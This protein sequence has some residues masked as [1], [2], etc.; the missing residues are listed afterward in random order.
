[1]NNFWVSMAHALKTLVCKISTPSHV[2]ATFHTLNS[3]QPQRHDTTIPSFR[4]CLHTCWCWPHVL[5]YKAM[6]YHKLRLYLWCNLASSQTGFSRKLNLEQTCYL[7]SC[8]W[9]TGS[10]VSYVP[11]SCVPESCIH[12]G[13]AEGFIV[14]SLV[15]QTSDYHGLDP[16]SY[17][18]LCLLVLSWSPQV[19][20]LEQPCLLLELVLFPHC[21]ALKICHCHPEHLVELIRG[22][23]SLGGHVEADHT[24]TFCRYLLQYNTTRNKKCV[25]CLIK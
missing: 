22:Q 9:V 8:L 3:L 17:R 6:F 10:R 14:S 4:R 25:Q 5:T 19:F 13:A 24:S 18:A 20:S 2:M 1:M 15:E 21:Q 23:V 16:S 12:S 7:L 11:E